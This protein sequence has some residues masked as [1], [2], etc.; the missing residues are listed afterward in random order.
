MSGHNRPATHPLDALQREAGEWGV[1]TF[2]HST[3]ASL[4]AHLADEVA[5]LRA[6][7][8]HPSDGPGGY[9]EEAADC[10]LFLLDLAHRLEF[11]LGAAAAAKLAVAKQSRFAPPDARGVS[12]RLREE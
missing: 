11:S 2:P 10:L 9:Q 3:P 7:S 1:A 6:A 5:E 12:R 8:Q 4:I